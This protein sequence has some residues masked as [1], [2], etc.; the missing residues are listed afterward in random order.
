M[1]AEP[2]GQST[3][4]AAPL[5]ERLDGWLNSLSWLWFVL[6]VICGSIAAML[7]TT[8][9]PPWLDVAEYA[10][11][12]LFALEFGARF[13]AA[14]SRRDFFRHVYS[15]TDGVALLVELMLQTVRT[16]QLL[17]SERDTRTMQIVRLSRLWR[18][19]K[20]IRLVTLQQHAASHFTTGA[21]T[22]A[23]IDVLE[24][25][26]TSFSGLVWLHDVARYFTMDNV[27]MQH[28]GTSP[29]SPTAALL[30]PLFAP[31]VL[32][33]VSRTL[34]YA[35]RNVC[36]VR[37]QPSLNLNLLSPCRLASCA[38]FPLRSSRGHREHPNP[39]RRGRPLPKPVR[40]LA[41]ACAPAR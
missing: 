23:F 5:R 13:Y 27:E 11:P 22:Q 14:P 18:L 19:S 17:Q 38:R 4:D 12:L 1:L 32:T 8:A 36:S 33:G 15:A 24:R 25:L 2:E 40:H 28:N 34:P 7:A 21:H 41:L 9:D 3:T 29:L 39:S 30:S 10:M 26:S 37:S 16:A 20:A 35:P 6:L 31:A